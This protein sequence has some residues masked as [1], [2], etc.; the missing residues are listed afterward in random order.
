MITLEL[1]KG[2]VS[3]YGSQISLSLTG[4]R[5]NYRIRS[6]RRRGYY[7]FRRA[8]LCGY[9][10]RAATIRERRLLLTRS[11]MTALGTSEVEE[12]GPFADIH[13]NEDE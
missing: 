10:S 7:L 12:A 13:D 5:S 8:I 9:N 1:W 4:R 11:E 2:P 3:L 6:I